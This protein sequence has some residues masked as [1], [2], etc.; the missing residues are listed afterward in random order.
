MCFIF[1]FSLSGKDETIFIRIYLSVNEIYLSIYISKFMN[2][3]K[4]AIK[5]STLYKIYI[6]Q[7]LIFF[8]E[9]V[10]KLPM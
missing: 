9:I 10:L 6:I 4:I 7:L 5:Y 2:D 3:G 8:L 1:S